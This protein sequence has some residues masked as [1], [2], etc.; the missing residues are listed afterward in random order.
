M[1]H[2]GPRGSPITE[3]RQGCPAIAMA[4]ATVA[5]AGKVTAVPFTIRLISSDI[6][7]VPV[8]MY[9]FG[10]CE[11]AP[12]L[13]SILPSGKLTISVDNIRQSCTSGQQHPAWSRREKRS[14]T[15][16]GDSS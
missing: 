7:I 6:F 5:P 3:V 1:P 11:L 8:M 10:E 12:A 2:N 14:L 9:F 15:K 4:T 13:K 16:R